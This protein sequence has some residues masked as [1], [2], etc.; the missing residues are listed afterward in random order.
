MIKERISNLSILPLTISRIKVSAYYLFVFF[1][2]IYKG[3]DGQEE[4]EV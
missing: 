4:D 3:L 1:F 2:F